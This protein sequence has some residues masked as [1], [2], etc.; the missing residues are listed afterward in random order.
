MNSGGTR[1]EAADGPSAAPTA[2][3]VGGG[4]RTRE[5][6]RYG[7]LR[8]G[9]RVAVVAPSGPVD[10]V[11]LEAGCAVLRRVGLDPAV[12]KHTLDLVNLGSLGTV[13]NDWHRL[14]GS[15]TDRA[16]DLQE[17]W[18]DP[19]IRA[20]VCARGGYGATRVLDHLDWAA[21]ADATEASVA[22][23]R[24]PKILHGSSDITALHAAFGARLGV[25][26][27]FGPMPAGVIADLAPAV[28]QDMPDERLEGLRAALF[29]DPVVL[30]GTR[31]LR[32]G[33]AEGPLTGG[34]LSLLT[35]LL[36][37]PYAPP[38]AAGRV[39]FLEDVTEAP[40]RID[41]MLVQLLQAGWFD[42][43]AGIALGSWHD[44]GDP[45]ELDSVLT[46]RLGPL[47][48]PI[49]AG[50]PAGHGPRQHTLELG[51]PALLDTGSLELGVPDV[52][53]LTLPAL[54]GGAR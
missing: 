15:D 31:A 5:T 3:R 48:V 32:P 4:R 16:A 35:A 28:S 26:T 29:G 14:A 36:G 11:R 45:A 10:P 27:S 20:V 38:P 6:R 25:T 37:T 33:R 47:G 51:A 52:G 40:Y 1:A 23:G 24:G 8:P 18:C 49:L 46:A 30:P 12:G 13:R 17:A 41:R 21:L 42:G 50:V 22:S 2:D 54:P 9:D 39:V 19:E 53:A 7:R 34:T 43:A 44:C